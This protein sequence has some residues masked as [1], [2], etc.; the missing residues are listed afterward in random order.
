MCGINGFSWLDDDLIKKMNQATKNRGPDDQGQYIESDISLGHTRLSIIDLSDKGH[1]PM[2]NEDGTI[3]ITYNGEI[4]NYQDIR[5]NLIRKG[6]VFTSKSDTEVIIHAYEEYGLDFVNHFNGMW[7][8]C[9]YDKKERLLILSRDQ[10]GI[11]PLYYSLKN[12]EIIFSSL[13]SG[14]LCHEIETFP[15]DKAIMDFLAFN[16]EDHDNFTFF[17]NIQ[18]IPTDTILLYKISEKKHFFHQWYYPKFRPDVTE[19]NIRDLFKNSVYLRTI[20]DVPIGCCLSGGIDSSAIVCTLNIF[21]NDYFNTY[22][23]INP[24]YQG[25]ESQYIK[26]VGKLIQANQYFTKIDIKEFL[27]NFN[28]FVKAQEEP[29]TGMSPFAQ[30]QV[31]K[32][33]HQ[34]NAKVLLDGQGGDEIF[35]GYTYYFSYFFLE[36][37]KKGKFH[38]CLLEMKMY[39][40]NFHDLLP[41]GMFFFFF[42]PKIVKNF[43]WKRYIIPWIKPEYYKKYC[44]NT[45]DPRWKCFDVK[46][47]LS[48]TLYSTAIPHLLRWEDKNAMRWGIESRPPFLDKNLV[49]TALSLP[50]A[51]KLHG[52]K[53]KVV[54]KQAISDII[55]EAIKNRKDKIGFAV[56]VDDFLRNIDVANYCSD[57]IY[58][59]SF[60]KRPYWKWKKVEQLYHKHQNGELNI[61]DT[62]W[63]WINLEIWLREFFT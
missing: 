39:Y 40:N 35:A 54:F 49:E 46:S 6:H 18:K 30:Y 13:I 37:L 47:I 48:L 21:I 12:N 4:F 2:C 55:P 5:N 7:A 50:S 3:W 57:I 58:S 9:I 34:H 56:P 63:K 19:Q 53:T 23:M 45:S 41:I 62:I 29:V 28:D 44:E 26:E 17:T 33:A 32:L 59:E 42:F 15:N 24:G 27:E 11:K 10:F 14:I 22:S 31:M 52:G 51:A 60:R 25:D 1:Q 8:F 38:S 61:G 20:S 36:L 43:I 16:L